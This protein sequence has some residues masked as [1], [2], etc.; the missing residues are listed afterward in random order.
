M[1][2]RS[3]PV[4]QRF[5]RMCYRHTTQEHYCILRFKDSIRLIT[6]HPHAETHGQLYSRNVAVFT[7]AE[8]ITLNG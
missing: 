8:K 3:L 2:V 7:R 4:K 6:E 5:Y 1:K